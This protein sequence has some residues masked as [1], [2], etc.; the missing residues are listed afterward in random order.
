MPLPSVAAKL[1]TCGYGFE[2]K[3]LKILYVNFCD[4]RY[5]IIGEEGELR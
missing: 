3:C 4:S 5:I 2:Q 1:I